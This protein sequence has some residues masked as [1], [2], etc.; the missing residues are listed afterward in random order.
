MFGYVLIDKPQ[1]RICEYDAYTSV[2]C[3]LCKNIKKNY[4]ILY[5]STLNYDFTFLALLG[6]AITQKDC[7]FEKKHCVC[8]PFKSCGYCKCDEQIMD[9]TSAAAMMMV[10]YKLLDNI[11]DTSFFKRMLLRILKPFAKRPFKKAAK[12]YPQMAEHF[13][14][15]IE[16]SNNNEKD[17]SCSIDKAADPTAKLL[18]YLFISLSDDA[19][20]KRVLDRLGYCMGRWIYLMDAVDD[21][22]E[23]KK[24]NSF[25]P[26]ILAGKSI[27][28]CQDVQSV[29]NINVSEAANCLDLLEFKRFKDIIYNIVCLGMPKTQNKVFSKYRKDEEVEGSI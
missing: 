5:T 19:V 20:E 15:Q 17:H 14:E 23:D 13:K 29:L 12:R 25:N 3:G 11:N 26:L 18:S 24:Q 22:E 6:F 7:S 10:Y 4:G 9:M 8:N 1:L 16:I 28:D 2:Y 21:Y 27:E